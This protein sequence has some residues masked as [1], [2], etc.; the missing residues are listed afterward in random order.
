MRME[1]LSLSI[2]VYY[3]IPYTIPVYDCDCGDMM[4]YG[5]M[6]GIVDEKCFRKCRI[7]PFRHSQKVSKIHQW[8]LLFWDEENS[9]CTGLDDRRAMFCQRAHLLS[10]HPHQEA[11]CG[12][13]RSIKAWISFMSKAFLGWA[14]HH[15]WVPLG[16]STG[17]SHQLLGSTGKSMETMKKTSGSMNPVEI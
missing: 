14:S 5:D 8:T 4:G 6:N 3:T 2:I 15:H 16:I 1:I 13:S 10:L 9:I 12:W 7:A 11:T 17:M